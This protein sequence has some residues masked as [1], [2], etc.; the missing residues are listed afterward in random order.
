M[1]VAL[2]T[3]VAGGIGFATAKLLLE[4][5]IAVVGMDVIPEMREE[6][7]GEFTY[8]SGDLS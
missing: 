1:K 3:G 7:S 5:G 8:F 2:V 6:L 4:K